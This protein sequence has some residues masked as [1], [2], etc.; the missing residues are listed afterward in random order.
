[1]VAKFSGHQFN[2]LAPVYF[3][4]KRPMQIIVFIFW[5]GLLVDYIDSLARV[6][7]RKMINLKWACVHANC[8]YGAHARVVGKFN[9]K[10]SSDKSMALQLYLLVQL[11]LVLQSFY[12][13]SKCQYADSFV[14]SDIYRYNSTPRFY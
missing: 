10:L 4:K 6:I 12:C 14:H 7:N 3:S 11:S 1:M 13:A 8:W 5:S 9:Y 2:L